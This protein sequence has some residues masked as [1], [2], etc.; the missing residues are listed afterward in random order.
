MRRLRTLGNL[1]C[2]NAA[3]VSGVP[4]IHCWQ[5]RVYALLC[6][7][8]DPSCSRASSPLPRCLGVSF[9]FLPPCQL[10]K[11]AVYPGVGGRMADAWDEVA[12]KELSRHPRVERAFG[13][14]SV[15]AVEMKAADRG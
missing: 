6:W 7:D 8:I 9:R 15:L 12:V 1:V 2:V 13:L 4:S 14:G 10:E 11:S 5:H 3:G